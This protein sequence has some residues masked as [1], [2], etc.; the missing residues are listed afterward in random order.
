MHVIKCHIYPLKEFKFPYHHSLFMMTTI[1]SEKSHFQTK[2][3]VSGFLQFSLLQLQLIW[4]KGNMKTE[5]AER[6]MRDRTSTASALYSKFDY[7]TRE[8]PF[9]NSNVE[10]VWINI[11]MGKIT[12]LPIGDSDS[13]E[14]RHKI[15]IGGADPLAHDRCIKFYTLKNSRGLKILRGL[16]PSL[17][18]FWLWAEVVIMCWVILQHS[19]KIASL[20]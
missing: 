19:H 14:K 20:P 7:C 1:S 11:Q 5:M 15:E 8:K 10:T 4:P 6:K 13:W 12:G 9:K 2:L 3:H 17:V 16:P 18:H